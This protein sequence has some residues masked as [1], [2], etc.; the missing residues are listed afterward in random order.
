MG[1]AKKLQNAWVLWVIG[2]AV[3]AVA[4][5]GV[6]STPSGSALVLVLRGLA[7]TGYQLV[8]WA[9]LSSAF[10]PQL[11]RFFGRPFVKV[12]HLASVGGLVCITLHPILVAVNSGSAS[13]FLPRFDS[14]R[15]FLALGGRP[16]WYLIAAAVIAAVLR[17]RIGK[18]WRA[19]HA[20]NYVA[21][22]LVTAHAN[23]L[24]D[25]FQSPVFR[26]GS[27]VLAAGMLAVFVR[28]RLQVRCT[29]V[30]KT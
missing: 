30:R 6:T 5:A 26:V 4:G 25:S 24:G 3:V 9:I 11:V 8:F 18:G 14:L 15:T 19:V 2:L 16:A 20:L 27:W 28:R 10:V 17:Q 1:R 22:A 23:L 21:F 29:A 12:H 13:V 7:L